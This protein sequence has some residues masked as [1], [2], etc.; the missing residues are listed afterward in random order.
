MTS[1]LDA[2]VASIPSVPEH[3]KKY[4]KVVMTGTVIEIYEMD[5][6]PYQLFESYERKNKP[7]WLEQWEAELDLRTLQDRI[8]DM[9]DIDDI[10]DVV[11][12]HHRRQNG[13]ITRTR[14]M[15]RRLSLANF[16][17]G[18]KFVTFTFAEN[19]TDVKT[20]NALWKLFILRM[21][22]K[23]GKFK[24]MAVLEFQKRGAVHY[25][26]MTDLPYIKK[27]ELAEIWGNGFIKI[28][29]I[30]HVDNVG[31][32]IVKYMTKDLFDERFVAQKAYQ[33]SK[34]LNRPVTL[35][36]DLAEEIIHLYNLDAKKTVYESSYTSEHHG[37]I[38]YKEYNLKRL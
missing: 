28:N 18:S 25:H 1:G 27:S 6:K 9:T 11:K 8:K 7:D 15:V 37:K 3:Q 21:R 14:N 4:R 2:S 24:Y 16:D 32:Y 17:N 38:H 31:A 12:K 29:R 13:N 26:C 20:A 35:R 5:E 30:E 10:F 33:C 36:D 19:V 23:Y 34:G 22:Y